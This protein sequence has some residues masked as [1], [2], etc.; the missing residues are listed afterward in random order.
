MSFRRLREWSWDNRWRHSKRVFVP[1]LIS[2]LSFTVARLYDLN[3]NRCWLSLAMW[4]MGFDGYS[5]LDTINP[6]CD[7][8]GKCQKPRQP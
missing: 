1:W 3:P 6:S 2:E 4:A 7:G 8:C 5:P